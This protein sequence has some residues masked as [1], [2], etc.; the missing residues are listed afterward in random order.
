MTD[1]TT[2]RTY[3]K[4]TIYPYTFY[5]IIG[6]M[7]GFSI[8]VILYLIQSLSYNYNSMYIFINAILTLS[9]ILYNKH[10]NK[11]ADYNMSTR[12]PSLNEDKSFNSRSKVASKVLEYTVIMFI[13]ILTFNIFINYTLF[14]EINSIIQVISSVCVLITTI[15]SSLIVKKLMN[16]SQS[17]DNLESEIYI[18]E[19]SIIISIIFYI[20]MNVY[21]GYISEYNI[22][23]H[24]TFEYS[25]VD[26]IVTIIS[27]F[28]SYLCSVFNT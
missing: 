17:I 10:S 8:L 4:S 3:I 24:L 13:F 7:A 14:Y 27:L 28:I 21:F 25:F 9:F 15:S 5:E 16:N 1:K 2:P 26:S 22:V 12:I 11:V 20:F 23:Y 19:W 18:L 6:F